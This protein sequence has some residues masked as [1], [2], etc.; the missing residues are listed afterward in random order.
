MM[1][2]KFLILLDQKP[3]RPWPYR[4]THSKKRDKIKKKKKICRKHI[5]C[6]LWFQTT[7]EA[8]IS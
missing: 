8:M 7:G 5:P 1:E 2:A 3:A 6:V 4:T